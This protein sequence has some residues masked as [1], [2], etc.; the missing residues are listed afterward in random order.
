LQTF[1]LQLPPFVFAIHTDIPL[2]IKNSQLIYGSAFL[3]KLPNTEFVDYHITICFSGGIRKFYKPQARFLS[4]ER[5]PFKP[6]NANQA[7]A[8]ME[9]GM[10]W[11]VAAY[12]LQY[13]II[14][15]SLSEL[16]L[17]LIVRRNGANRAGYSNSDT[18]R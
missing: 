10:N 2:V 18:L 11:T 6:L 1:Y 16:R 17:A 13:V 4:D 3:E 12:E 9:W 15:C 7:Y 8:M 5:E 14:H